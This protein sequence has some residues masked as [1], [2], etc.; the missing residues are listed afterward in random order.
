M[1]KVTRLDFVGKNQFFHV[2]FWQ[3]T[4][5]IVTQTLAAVVLATASSSSFIYQA[6]D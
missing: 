6:G 1:V 2:L 5:P 3:L 4:C